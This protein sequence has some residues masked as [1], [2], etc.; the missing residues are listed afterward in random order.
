MAT[1]YRAVEISAPGK[2][3][4]VERP[5]QEPGPGQLRIR[6]E[7]AGVCHS[8]VAT[9]QN[10]W[11]G[12]TLPRVPG[13]EIA[14]RVDAIGEGVKGWQH[15]Q[16][17]AVGWFGGQCNYCEPCRRGLFVDCQNLI[18]TG[19]SRDG[20]YAEMAIVE[21]RAAAAVPEQLERDTVAP[22]VCAG[23]TTF[24]A[25][26]KS[27]LGGGARV[28]VHGIGGLGHLAVQFSRKMGFETVA[29]ARGANKQDL[30]RQLGAHL[31]IDNAAT[32]SVD[33]LNKMGGVDAIVTTSSDAESIGPLI[34]ALKPHGRLI[35]L[36]IPFDP[37]KVSLV[38]LV[39]GSRL[40][41]SSFVGTAIEEE[42]TLHFSALQDVKP[43]VERVPL[44]KAE[45][46]YAKLMAGKAR[47]RMVLDPSL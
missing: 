6:I 33:V 30:A 5:L 1:T 31:Y 28:A 37:I 9:V 34:G 17:V 35:A 44:E 36:G 13:H 2:F 47:F 4:L 24:N 45:E 18:I 21:A 11:P 26:R 16:R 29:I 46:A 41:T 10:A 32:D 40:I 42:D 12:L 27:G 25:L 39:V 19:I 14:G 22:L 23:V 3:T 20:G 38:Q 43:I 8:D 15:G 7:E